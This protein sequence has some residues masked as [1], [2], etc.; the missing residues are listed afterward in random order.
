[1][2]TPEPAGE[3]VSGSDPQQYPGHCRRAMAS[4][5]P[6]AVSDPGNQAHRSAALYGAF[7]CGASLGNAPMG[8]HH[9]ICH[10]LGGTYNL[11]HGDVHAAVLPYAMAF[12]RDAAPHAMSQIAAAL[13]ATDAAAG[14]L[15]LNSAVGAPKN[16]VDV[17]FDTANIDE[18]ADI[19]AQARFPNPRPVTV[20]GVRALL[21]AASAGQLPQ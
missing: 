9:K 7:L 4:A 18:V 11:P 15:Q 16:L 2:Q 20:Q 6:G 14:L 5:L 12:N 8:I 1:M 17:G 3:K 21:D 10:V 19:V 13:G